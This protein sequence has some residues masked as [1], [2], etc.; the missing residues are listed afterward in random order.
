MG[1]PTAKLWISYREKGFQSKNRSAYVC[2]TW[3]CVGDQKGMIDKKSIKDSPP[4]TQG[5]ED[6]MVNRLDQAG[7]RNGKNVWRG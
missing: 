1:I 2:S 4:A 6:Y 3:E 7:A 5:G